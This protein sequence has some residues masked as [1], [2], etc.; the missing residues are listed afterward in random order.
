MRDYARETYD[1][2][3]DA[4]P[5]LDET[6]Y[7]RYVDVIRRRGVEWFEQKVREWEGDH[8]EERESHE[9]SSIDT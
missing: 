6:Y 9:T 4:P 2:L 3:R 8:E 7:G 5:V 1:A